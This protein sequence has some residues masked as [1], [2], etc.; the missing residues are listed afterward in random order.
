LPIISKKDK[1]ESYYEHLERLRK[2]SALNV[3]LGKALVLERDGS[4]GT[5]MS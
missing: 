1:K 4:S 3:L 2:M 5:V